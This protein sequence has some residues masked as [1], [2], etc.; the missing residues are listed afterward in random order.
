MRASHIV[1]C[2][3]RK[4]LFVEGTVVAA[5][6][7]GPGDRLLSP[8]ESSVGESIYTVVLEDLVQ[9]DVKQSRAR[10]SV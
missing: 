9:L 5:R 3:R 2:R 1:I 6:R 4:L 8:L 10:H 7:R